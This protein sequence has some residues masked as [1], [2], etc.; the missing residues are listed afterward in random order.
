MA[1]IMG[2]LS[3]C[4][5]TCA[6][7]GITGDKR[8][9][10]YTECTDEMGIDDV[11]RSDIKDA[12]MT[13]LYQSTAQPKNLFG[14]DTSELR[15]FYEALVTVAPGACKV[16]S[17]MAMSWQSNALTHEWDM[18][19]GFH[20]R[21]PVLQKVQSKIEIDELDH[22]SLTYMYEENIGTEYGLSSAAK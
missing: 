7:V 19:D 8:M 9:D 15:A 18:V 4:P 17:E 11:P 12:F 5:V 10:I 20:V 6:N 16:L 21:V 13:Y 3:N 14:D 2:V 1:T 22:M